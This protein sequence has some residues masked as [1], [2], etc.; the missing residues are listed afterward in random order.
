MTQLEGLKVV[1]LAGQELG[2]VERLIETGAND[3]M[4]VR[5]DRERWIP[6]TMPVM[7]QVDLAAGVIQVDWDADF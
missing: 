6:V 2:Q 4:V 3:V 5:G 1:N 7:R